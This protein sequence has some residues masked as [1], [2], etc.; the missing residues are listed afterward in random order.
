M[1]NVFIRS[2]IKIRFS[3]IFED[4]IFL[5]KE[6]TGEHIK[7]MRVKNGVVYGFHKFVYDCKK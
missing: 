2:I 4:L 7:E 3:K 1:K 5:D 6:R